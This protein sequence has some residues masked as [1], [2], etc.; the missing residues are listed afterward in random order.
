MT[1]AIISFEIAYRKENG[2]LAIYGIEFLVVAIFMLYL[3]Y[4]IFELDET[5]KKY[6]LIAGLYV[7]IYYILKSIYISIKTKTKYMNSI[8]DVK[9]II[10][11]K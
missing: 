10:K 2:A 8:S 7:A 3:P 4:V 5:H 11:K 1:I 6:Y 9:E